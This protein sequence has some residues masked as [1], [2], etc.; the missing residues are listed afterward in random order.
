MSYKKIFNEVITIDHIN[1]MKELIPGYI[2]HINGNLSTM[3]DN[4]L[5]ID[6]I[7]EI[8]CEDVINKFDQIAILANSLNDI[9]LELKPIERQKIEKRHFLINEII[10]T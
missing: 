3:S 5:I 1:K 9:I 2:N 8:S 6:Y 4:L 10:K 7:D